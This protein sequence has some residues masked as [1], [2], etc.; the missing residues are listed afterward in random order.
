[1]E[2]QRLFIIIA[3]VVIGMLLFGNWQQD[4][5]QLAKE[6]RIAQ[7]KEKLGIS[8]KK[9]NKVNTSKNSNS[10]SNSNS[11]SNLPS[12]PDAEEEAPKGVK[13]KGEKNLQQGK[14]I[15]IKTD[16]FDIKINTISA[17]I[18]EVNLLQYPISINDKTPYRILS[19][20]GDKIYITESGF[21]VSAKHEVPAPSHESLYT[22][23]KT[24]YQLEKG[25]DTL[26]VNFLWEKDGITAIKTYEFKRGKYV[27]TIR[28]NIINKSKKYWS[29]SDY[30][31]IKR[32]KP[33][34]EKSVFLPTFTGAA[35]FTDE[36][37][38]QKISFD[39]IVEYRDEALA[40][41]RT[42]DPKKVY[43]SQKGGWISMLEHYFIGTWIANPKEKYDLYSNYDDGFYRVGIRKSKRQRVE[44]GASRVFSN[45][46]YI[47]PKIEKNLEPLS[48]KLEL[49]ID[50]GWLT[51]ISKPLFWLL[52][53]LH[54]FLGNWGWAIIFLTIL[55]KAA[56]YKLSEASYKSMAKMREIHPRLAAL[57]ERHGDDKQALHQAMMKMY[58]TEKINPFGGCLPI[59]IQIPVFIALYY[60]LLE[61]VELRQMPWML[62][63]Q[64]LAI[65]DPYFVLP[66][67]M[68]ATMIFQHKLNPAPLDPIQAK[69][70]MALPIIFTVF[71]LFF[72]AGLVLYWCIN[73]MLSIAQQYYIT[74]KI[75]GGK[76]V[77][78]KKE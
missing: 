3:L 59:L 20:S 61:S 23:E 7:N 55:I 39:D 74:K 2:N 77:F 41:G 72:P 22:T 70:M 47:G 76:P 58:K 56:F 40:K 17:D 36:D 68:G 57:K 62:W 10:S 38:Y 78:Q 65:P 37:G 44:V 9:T 25:K 21:H 8:G 46:I 28:Y 16:V 75:S 60:V 48:K 1:M 69:V 31:E 63:I 45:R 6:Y 26:L 29:A 15:S 5:L 11:K 42:S 4:Q 64:D 32:T 67:I 18:Q 54:G 12:A 34:T 73:N 49:S 50:F 33:S 43:A 71:F 14:M 24:S 19:A 51:V 52:D 66:I 53:I 27:V 13:V 30:W 35:I